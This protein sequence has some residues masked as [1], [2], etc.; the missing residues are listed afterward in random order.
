[1]VDQNEAYTFQ[2]RGIFY[3]SKRVPSDLREF[4]KVSRL[5]YSLKTKCPKLANTQV[6]EALHKLSLYWNKVRMDKELPCSQF[7]VSAKNNQSNYLSI[8]FTKAAHLY[9]ESKGKHRGI[10][11]YNS[12]QRATRYIISSIG[13]KNLASYTR[14]NAN[15]FRD[16]L[17]ERE[18]AGSS[19][20]RILAIVKAIFNFANN[21]YGLSLKN[22]FSGLQ[23]DR[24]AR[25]ESR[26]PIPIDNIRVIQ[27]RCIEIDDDLRWLVALISDTGMRLAEATGLLIEDI[28]LNTEVPLVSVRSYSWRRLKTKGSKRDIPLVGKAS[29]SAKRIKEMSKSKFAFPRYNTSTFTNTNTASASLNKWLRSEGFG[30]YTMHCFRHSLRDRLR[31]VDCP[32]EITDQIG[33]WSNK[34]VGQ[35]YGNGYRLC[36]LNIWMQRMV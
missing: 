20:T 36:D 22:H 17:L 33:G 21:E 25:V 19:I 6:K 4:Y 26:E 27:K 5:T 1:M 23:Y 10:T 24:F 34:T 13:D 3:F 11:F 2:K 30:Q 15:S 14:A 7:L 16:Y 9:Q 35:N 12:V 8:K 29:W 18:L 32:F 31:Y 28:R